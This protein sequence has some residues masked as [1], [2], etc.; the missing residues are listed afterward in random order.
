MAVEEGT[1]PG[2]RAH[3]SHPCS[4]WLLEKSQRVRRWWAPLTSPRLAHEGHD[5][6]RGQRQGEVFQHLEAGAAGVAGRSRE[7]PSQTRLP[8]LVA[9]VPPEVSL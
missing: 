2:G 5:L 1:P 6:A 9:R 8:A 7:T 4:E 3:C